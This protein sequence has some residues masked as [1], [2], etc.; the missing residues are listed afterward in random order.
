[1]PHSRFFLNEPLFIN[2]QITLNDDEFHHLQVMRKRVDDMIEVVNGNN[3]LAIAKV[4]KINQKSATAQVIEILEGKS[5]TPFIILAQAIVRPAKLDFIFEKCTELGVY[6][7]ILYKAANS[8]MEEISENKQQRINSILISAIKQCGRL[9][10]PKFSIVDD[11]NK[12]KQLDY[13][14]F[15][16]DFSSANLLDINSLKNSSKPICFFVGPEQGFTEKEHSFF[17]Q[18]QATPVKINKNI[19]RTET[20]AIAA[21]ALL[22]QLHVLS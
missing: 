21:S 3:L 20:A 13:K 11:L 17:N 5:K 22:A 15:Y 8:D 10:L 2:K 14:Y 12:F 18:I 4:L 16:G 9:S 19:L 1:M 6:E 7:F